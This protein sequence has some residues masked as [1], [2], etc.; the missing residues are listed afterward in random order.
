MQREFVSSFY[1]FLDTTIA[2][3]AGKGTKVLARKRFST[4]ELPIDHNELVVLLLAV[5]NDSE[6]QCLLE[7]PPH[8][9]DSHT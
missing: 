2:P 5:S 4:C 7:Y 9:L 3:Q 1:N 6:R 8:S